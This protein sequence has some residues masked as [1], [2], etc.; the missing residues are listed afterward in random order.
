MVGLINKNLVSPTKNEL[1]PKPGVFANKTCQI[2]SV[3]AKT[4]FKIVNKFDLLT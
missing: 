3:G 4:V 1:C 2:M